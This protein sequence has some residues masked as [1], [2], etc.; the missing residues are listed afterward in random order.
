MSDDAERVWNLMERFPLCT[1]TTWDGSELRSRPMTA[2]VRRRNETI[3]LFADARTYT[4]AATR[5][6]PHACLTFADSASQQIVSVTGAAQMSADRSVIREL[7]S[8]LAKQS[9]DS[10]DNPN[11]RMLRVTPQEARF[12][13]GTA[14]IIVPM[15]VRASGWPPKNGTAS[16]L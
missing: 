10:A 12:W 14:M 11:I 9:W 16:T 5:A 6:H 15:G 1:L 2:F 8:T 7:W 4:D 3:Y 13:D